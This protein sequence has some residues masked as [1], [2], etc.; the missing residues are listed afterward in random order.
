MALLKDLEWNSSCS[1]TLANNDAVLLLVGR[2]GHARVASRYFCV[3]PAIQFWKALHQVH[4][5]IRAVAKTG[6]VL[7]LALRAK[8]DSPSLLHEW[9]RGGCRS[10]FSRPR[11]L[12]VV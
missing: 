11:L 2:I 1:E 6:A 4:I 7:G 8:H 10:S 12:L 5:A 9:E 3:C